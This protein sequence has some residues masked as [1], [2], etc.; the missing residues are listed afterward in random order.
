MSHIPPP[1]PDWFKINE[2]AGT[3]EF[4]LEGW[5][6]VIAS[7][8]YLDGL[9]KASMFE[10]FDQKFSEIQLSP[11][12]IDVTAAYSSDKAVYPLSYGIASAIVSAL[13][14]PKPNRLD[15]CDRKLQEAGQ[16]GFAENAHL[17]VDF[18]ASKEQIMN[19]FEAWLIPAL[20]EYYGQ[21]SSRK[22][23]I[24][25][26]LI[27]AWHK[28]ALLPY[29]DLFLWYRRQGTRMPSDSVLA[30]WLSLETA[31]MVRQARNKSEQIFVL[32]TLRKLSL[33]TAAAVKAVEAEAAAKAAEAAARL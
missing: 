23:G 7:R 32:S 11:F 33:G 22:A 20:S 9:F 3:S 14:S 1:P 30:S 2:Y 26:T 12:D 5:R 25:K 19:D 8:I 10:L 17:T 27:S 4:D 18:N 16:D 28:F 6:I 15:S 29:Q 13:A 21:D 31:D 24:T